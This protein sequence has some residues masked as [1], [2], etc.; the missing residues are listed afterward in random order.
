MVIFVSVARFVFGLERL[1][2]AVFIFGSFN[3]SPR[4]ISRSSVLCVDNQFVSFSVDLCL[5][6]IHF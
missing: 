3:L 4:D 5:C 6:V 2:V 1:L